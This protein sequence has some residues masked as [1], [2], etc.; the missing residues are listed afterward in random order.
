MS[1]S[2]YILNN[3]Y[4]SLLALIASGGGGGGSVNNPMT[5]DLNAG[6]FDIFNATDIN[7]IDL[8]ASADATANRVIGTSLVQGAEINATD[9]LI[10]TDFNDTSAPSYG[11]LGAIAPP[12]Q[13]EVATIDAATA[14]GTILG[15]LRG[16]DVGFKQT[17][18]FQVIAYGAKSVIRILNNVAESDT[19]IFSEISYGQ[20]TSNPAR[21]SILFTCSAASATC[22]CAFYQ[23][24]GDKGTLGAYGGAFV[25]SGANVIA[26]HAVIY[27]T[28]PIVGNTSGTSGNF[29]VETNLY[30]NDGDIKILQ[31]NN[32]STYTDPD[33][34]VNSNL[35]LQSA[36]S[37][38]LA[39]SV[40][41]DQLAS[42][43]GGGDIRVLSNTDF[44]NN[45]LKNTLDDFINID[46]NIDLQA[47]GHGI[48]NLTALTGTNGGADDIVMNSD[49][50][51]NNNAIHNID[52]IKT[53]NI[54]ENTLNNG[55]TLH[56]ETN[57]TN[58]KIINLAAPTS[59][60]D[61]AN[62]LYV[63]TVAGSSG[64]QN[65][66]VANLDG[67]NFNITN[68]N[69]MTATTLQNTDGG[70]M[71]S[72]GTFQH[73][74]LSIGD[75]GVGGDTITFA[76][77]TSFKIKNFGLST[78]YFDYDQ[79]TQTL[80]TEN[81]ARQELQNGATMEVKSGADIAVATGGKVDASPGG[82]IVFNSTA[83][84]PSNFGELSM[85]DVRGL[86][87]S[88]LPQS[89]G[90]VDTAPIPQV[91]G[92]S[93]MINTRFDGASLPFDT[94]TSWNNSSD[95][96]LIYGI[97]SNTLV[98]QEGLPSQVNNH[99]NN[100][101]V[102]NGWLVGI[103][104]NNASS[105]GGWVCSGGASIEVVGASSGSFPVPCILGDSSSSFNQE[106]RILP[107]AG[108]VRADELNRGGI[109]LAIRLNIPPGD[110]IDV[111]DPTNLAVNMNKI[112]IQQIPIV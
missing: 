101:V 23:N 30:A 67:G 38:K 111:L 56:N 19:P 62:K 100:Q 71:F 68:T 96:F 74:G 14:E 57:M 88:N 2:F 42:T 108:W 1:G 3:K 73:G 40:Q 8:N 45:L 34:A 92:C 106:N 84:A 5:S 78:T 47:G 66:M 35:N 49:V 15:V 80:T 48:V 65:P 95:G 13:Y 4:N 103:G 105:L 77:S 99:D 79:A 46:E 58:N 76:P 87:I 102:F 112:I 59:N 22:E 9:K 97:D 91:F 12:N 98:F 16:I 33:I 28:A 6:G 24:G 44:G 43:T 61:G 20:D 81:G 85:L 26:S 104:A 54:F 31:T 50:D 86:G 55:I 69:N 10:A 72:K 60:A 39:A 90:L 64:V 25:P 32:I 29:R 75:F 109:A 37:V 63:D 21:N 52:N 107:Q 94:G 110:T 36:S 83:A 51:M 70:N 53:D 93:T 7:A 17:I 41:T 89:F 82:S 18:Y 11:N 27:A